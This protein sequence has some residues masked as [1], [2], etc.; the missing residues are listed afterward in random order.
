MEKRYLL[1]LLLGIVVF[2][3]P[4][5][6]ATRASLVTRT[7]GSSLLISGDQDVQLPAPQPQ[8][9]SEDVPVAV[10]TALPLNTVDFGQVSVGV[11]FLVEQRAVTGGFVDD[12]VGLMF[13]IKGR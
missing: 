5:W 4:G 1:P 2:A 7:D 9:Q 12:G 8:P 3:A 10:Q 13:T 11:D 6:A